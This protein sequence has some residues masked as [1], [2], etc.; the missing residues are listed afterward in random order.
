MFPILNI[1]LALL[2]FHGQNIHSSMSQK[3]L[4]VFLELQGILCFVYEGA[5]AHVVK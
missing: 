4:A 2:C 3:A 1:Y 5:V